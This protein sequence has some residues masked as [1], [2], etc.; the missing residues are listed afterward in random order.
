MNI[1]LVDYAIY[2]PEGFIS[3]AELSPLVNVP[4][5]VLREKMG[6][7]SKRRG[8]P[9]DQPGIMAA[10]SAKALLDKTGFD[11]MD[12]DMILYG[13]ETYAEYG[14][15][16]VG[17]Y[18]QEEIGAK[19]A[20]A[21]DLSFRCAGLPLSL[22]VAKDMMLADP[23]LQNVLVCSGNNNAQLIDYQDPNQ[24]F[25]FNMAPGAFAMLLR[26]DHDENVILGSHVITDSSFTLDIVRETGGCANL[27]TQEM[28][29]EMAKDPE[30]IR[31]FNLL[32]LRDVESMRTRLNAVSG[33]HFTGVV[34]GACENSGITPADLE[35]FG[36]VH[37]GNRAHYGIM[38]ALELDEEKT[39]FLWEDGHCGQVDP[40]LAMDY[41]LKAGKVKDGDYVALVGAG[42]GYAFCSSIIRWGKAR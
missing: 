12:I 27:L 41:G 19:N 13:G 22:K 42:T 8:T 38:K 28:V 34:R 1:G 4:A 24:S 5:E 16:T 33:A 29:E 25:M 7:H 3:A 21:W 26:R 20:Y 15:W 11:P 2:L 31:R 9:E 6:I 23:K 32:T 30:K 40:L 10:K 39:V 36:C 37:I 18:V 17:I 14:C 35:F